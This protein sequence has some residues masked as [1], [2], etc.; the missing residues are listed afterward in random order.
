MPV[1]SL[2]LSELELGRLKSIA[3]EESKEKSSVARELLA[4]GIKFKTLLAYKE[5]KVS[6]SKLGK[7]LG[8]NV[9]QAIDFLSTFGIQSPVSYSDY[10]QARATAKKAIV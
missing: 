2:R 6:L 9:S 4:D 3:R 5:G 8:M 7:T 10:L 1:M